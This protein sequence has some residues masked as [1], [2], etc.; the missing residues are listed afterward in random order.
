MQSVDEMVMPLIKA[1]KA[2]T[3]V[4]PLVNNYDPTR[5]VWLENVGAFLMDPQAREN[6]RA[7]L[8]KFLAAGDYP[9]VSLDLENIPS[10]AQPG[11]RA[12]IAEL[13]ADLR[14]GKRIYIN[15][16]VDDDD[17]DLKFIAQHTDGVILMNY[18][19]HES[20][21]GPGP[22]AAAGLV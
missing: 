12:L 17:Y 15:V 20:E 1:E 14:P 5:N 19:Q 13:D 11:F 8:A 3:E 6:F 21:S 2:N 18:D 10:S 22:I 7:Q 9:G 4:F 16:P